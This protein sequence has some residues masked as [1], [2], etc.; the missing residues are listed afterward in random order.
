MVHARTDDSPPA[1]APCRAASVSGASVEAEVEEIESQPVWRERRA[2]R[3]CPVRRARRAEPDRATGTE[4]TPRR[5]RHA[6]RTAPSMLAQSA[7][8]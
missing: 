1:A 3:E 8:R 2:C 4:S 5:A 6:E 7:P